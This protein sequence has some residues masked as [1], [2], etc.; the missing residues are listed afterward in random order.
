VKRQHSG[1]PKVLIQLR[2]THAYSPFVFPG[3]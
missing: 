2:S 1:N 3:T